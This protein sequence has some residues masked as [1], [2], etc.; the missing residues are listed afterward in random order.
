MRATMTVAGSHEKAALETQL[1]YA[2]LA[3]LSRST[4]C[5][6]NI[7]RRSLDGGVLPPGAKDFAAARGSVLASYESDVAARAHLRAAAQAAGAHATPAPV[8]SPEGTVDESWQ[9]PSG[10][11]PLYSMLKA[12]ALETGTMVGPVV[13][14]LKLTG[15]Q[16]RAHAQKTAKTR[17]LFESTARLATQRPSTAPE[18]SSEAGESVAPF[19]KLGKRTPAGVMGWSSLVWSHKTHSI[20]NTTAHPFGAFGH[21]DTTQGHGVS[22]HPA[23]GL[24]KSSHGE[25]VMSSFGFRTGKFGGFDDHH[26]QPTRD[27]HGRLI[28]DDDDTVDS[29]AVGAAV[30]L[31][32]LDLPRDA[33]NGRLSS[34]A[35]G[36]HVANVHGWVYNS[37]LSQPPP[38]APQLLRIRTNPPVTLPDPETAAAATACVMQQRSESRRTAR[39]S[40]GN[41]ASREAPVAAEGQPGVAGAESVETIVEP[42]ETNGAETTA[43][44]ATNSGPAPVAAAASMSSVS[45]VSAPKARPPPG[46]ATHRT[47]HAGVM[48]SSLLPVNGHYPHGVDTWHPDIVHAVG[49]VKEDA[50]GLDTEIGKAEALAGSALKLALKHRHNE[51]GKEG[52][53]EAKEGEGDAAEDEELVKHKLHVLKKV[54]AGDPEQTGGR[55][56]GRG[57]A[58]KTENVA[59]TLNPSISRANHFVF[60]PA[61]TESA[62][63]KGAGQPGRASD[64]VVTASGAAAASSKGGDDRIGELSE[65]D[66]KAVRS[67]LHQLHSKNKSSRG[68]ARNG[69]GGALVNASYRSLESKESRGGSALGSG[70]ERQRSELRAAA[71]DGRRPKSE[72]RPRVW[73]WPHVDGSTVGAEAGLVA[74][75]VPTRAPHDKEDPAVKK[76]KDGGSLVAAMAK[77][78]KAGKSGSLLDTL[79]NVDPTAA[80]FGAAAATAPFYFYLKM[81]PAQPFP[82][83]PLPLPAPPS[84]RSDV[85]QRW[86]PAEGHGPNGYGGPAGPQSQPVLGWAAGTAGPNGA[87]AKAPDMPGPYDGFPVVPFGRGPDPAA[88]L[89]GAAPKVGAAP[90]AGTAPKVGAAPNVGAAPKVGAAPIAGAAP[91]VG[92]APNVGA[93]PR[94]GVATEG[95]AGPNLDAAGHTPSSALVASRRG[96]LPATPP[97][98]RTYAPLVPVAV[99]DLVPMGGMPPQRLLLLVRKPVLKPP[100]KPVAVMAAAPVPKGPPWD[101]KVS[102]IFVPRKTTTDA[103]SMTDSPF[104][105]PKAKMRWRAFQYD[106]DK[107]LAKGDRFTNLI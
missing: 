18:A 16:R 98:P 53:K 78:A 100:S 7:Y 94:I 85:F 50:K 91:K 103:R 102:S 10:Q 104:Q 33:R 32:E 25:E 28:A 37:H 66:R 11:N 24:Y 38:G 65:L 76:K 59:L 101:Y 47:V 17:S 96:C 51:G 71:G 48:Q 86:L 14:P 1:A 35:V 77:A 15:S 62:D 61:T 29:A 5:R 34:D 45:T 44:E 40:V 31:E 26:R 81:P 41:T 22:P 20:E 6:A 92:A 30:G 52:A 80:A 39:R 19:K 79:Q 97:A 3:N 58:Q 27:R 55:R 82:P 63:G 89:N 99:G 23:A 105:G 64:V 46:A 106:W 67:A 84:K 68:A 74:Y 90:D 9:V 54:L 60:R 49:V 42:V 73:M 87:W 70:V 21:L 75:E 43:K 107:C 8:A 69:G 13:R 83:P 12:R 88:G 72:A 93:A 2:C 57:V 4:P 36:K 56:L 95:E